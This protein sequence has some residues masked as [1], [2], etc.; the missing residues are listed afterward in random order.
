MKVKLISDLITM[1]ADIPEES[2]KRIIG[3]FFDE[4]TDPC[5]EG[6]EAIPEEHSDHPYDREEIVPPAKP[7]TSMF[8]SNDPPHVNSFMYRGFLHIK[9]DK[10]GEVRSFCA[11]ELVDSTVCRACGYE[12]KFTSPLKTMELRCSSCGK[13]FNYRT[14]RTEETFS[15]NCLECGAPV[16]LE[17]NHKKNYYQTMGSDKV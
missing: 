3:Y 5:P 9:C 8:W 14:N 16:D 13:I 1:S 15:H 7:A 12:V 17:L 10:C 11:K 4:V 6:Y 2:L